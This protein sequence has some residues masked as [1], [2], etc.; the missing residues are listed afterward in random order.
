[1][2]KKTESPKP[3]ETA[4]SGKGKR[5]CP[6]CKALVGVRKA[7]CD[8]GHEFPKAE[9]NGKPKAGRK[10]ATRTLD[11]LALASVLKKLGGVKKVQENIAEVAELLTKAKDAETKLAELGGVE[12]A[13]A[14][15]K[16]AQEFVEA[17]NAK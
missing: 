4:K 14:A 10:A 13:K 2:A 11:P 12:G 6:A 8:C 15:V 5:T 3:A 7:K 1:M 9:S 17:L 16:V